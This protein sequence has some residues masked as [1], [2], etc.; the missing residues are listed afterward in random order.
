VKNCFVSPGYDC[1]NTRFFKSKIEP[2][3]DKEGFVNLNPQVFKDVYAKDFCSTNCPENKGC[4]K[5]YVSTDPRLIDVPRSLVMTL[6][7]P[8]I[9]SS[10]KLKDIYT[11]Q[12]LRGYGQNYSTYS[13]VN[14]GQIMYYVGS[15]EDAFFNPIFSNSATVEG[16]MYK[17]P[18]GAMKPQY[19][20]K[21]LICRDPINTRNNN[22][23][24]GLSWLDDSQEFRENLMASQMRKR[25]EQRWEPRWTN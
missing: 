25:N 5:V 23:L 2:S 13:D 6:D 9:D 12:T 19:N 17:D 14:A 4:E 18:M 22:Y 24:S 3:S 11:D 20:R 16:T 21:P 15:I 8:P 10:M 1:D 7:R